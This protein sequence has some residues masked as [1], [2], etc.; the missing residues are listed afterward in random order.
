[1]SS[2]YVFCTYVLVLV[3]L[4]F[5]TT[6]THYVVMAYLGVLVLQYI[7]RSWFGEFC[8]PIPV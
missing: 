5:V 8:G 4:N 7:D 1:M 2:F 6:L 3:P